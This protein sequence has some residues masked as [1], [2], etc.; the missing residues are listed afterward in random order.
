MGVDEGSRTHRSRYENG[1]ERR[2]RKV[3]P[4]VGLQG[5]RNVLSEGNETEKR[6]SRLCMHGQT[7]NIERLFRMVDKP[8]K[9]IHEISSALL[10]SGMIEP[11]QQAIQHPVITRTVKKV[12]NFS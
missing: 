10:D 2:G 4:S 7:K 6:W 12:E 3:P 1:D 5:L 11:I 8:S 9:T